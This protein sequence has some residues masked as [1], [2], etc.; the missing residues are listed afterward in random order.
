MAEL[1]SFFVRLGTIF[2][3][4]GLKQA[5][6]SFKSTGDTAD[7]LT[8]GLKG[9]AAT[10]AGGAAIWK[11]VDFSVQSLDAFGEQERAERHL[12]QAMQNLGV[13][14]RRA[15]S[16]LVDFASAQQK[17]TTFQDDAIIEAEALLTTF[18]LYGEQLRKVALGAMDLAAGKQIDLATAA[19]VL[20][21]AYQ[22]TT[23]R[24]EQFGIK[25]QDTGRVA[26][27]FDQVMHQVQMK[28]GGAAAAETETYLGKV[29]MLGNN[30]G[31]LKEK[32]GSF[33]VGPAELYLGWLNKAIDKTTQIATSDNDALRR[34]QL[35]IQGL[36]DEQQAE[37]MAW[38]AFEKHSTDSEKANNNDYQWHL[39]K[40]EIIK[41]RILAEGRLQA[42]EEGKEKPERPGK[43]NRRPNLFTDE[44]EKV[45]EK[46]SQ[47]AARMADEADFAD[48]ERSE[49]S[50]VRKVQEMIFKLEQEG[51]YSQ[52]SLL[53]STALEKAE[54]ALRKKRIANI[55]ETLGQIATLSQAHNKNLAAIGKA[56]AMGQ[57]TIDTYAGVGKAWALGPIVGPPLAA[58][59]LVAGLANVARIAGVQL[60]KGGVARAT[61]GGVLANIAEGGQDEAVTPLT[62]EAGRK[63]GIGAGNGVQFTMH[64][65]N[66]F[67][68][69]GSDSKSG[70]DIEKLADK[71]RIATRDGVAELIDLSK[72]MY[73]TGKARAGE[74]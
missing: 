15:H 6:A 37:A 25:I 67:G 68:G 27:N 43:P 69:E 13:Y 17:L 2:D 19:N 60:A 48:A 23:G 74:A 1:A 35:T 59:V 53:R 38:V 50:K 26:E 12:E 55:G 8:G 52:A 56:A 20:G 7:K 65:T 51:K 72:E 42:V 47:E 70:T 21:K 45:R 31:E 63:L 32:V 10:V 29:K 41:Q 58:L 36:K 40:L 28:F 46:T 39:R 30:F 44:Q 18:G 34:R 11:L 14:T 5:Q 16:E 22:G 9:I 66:Y 4:S 24:L 49:R 61:P 64:Q 33:L 57:A 3:G 62:R 71:L 73:Q 54:D